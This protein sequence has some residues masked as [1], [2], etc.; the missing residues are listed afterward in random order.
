MRLLLNILICV[1]SNY[2]SNSR[3]KKIAIEN[4]QLVI[5]DGYVL[6]TN[7]QDSINITSGSLVTN[8]GITILTTTNA[9][10]I[11]SGGGLTILG[12]LSLQ[13]DILIGQSLKMVSANNPFIISG[14]TDNRVYVSPTTS[15][16]FT[17]TPNGIDQRF[18]LDNNSLNLTFTQPSLNA[19]TGS[20]VINGGGISINNSTNATGFTSGVL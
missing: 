20:L 12:G 10:D 5:Q 19:S 9:T 7:T 1:Y 18:R 2:M 4:N 3:L 16:L 6:L 8:G 11:N 17:I 14:L 13:K 15:P